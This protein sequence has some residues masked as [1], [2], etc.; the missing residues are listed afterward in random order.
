M[1]INGGLGL[2][3]PILWLKLEDY[4]RQ[5]ILSF[6]GLISDPHGNGYQIIQ[7]KVAI[8]SGGFWGKGFIQGSQTQLR[9]LPEQHTDFIF[10]VLG[11]E[12]GFI[13][14]FFV[15]ALL[16]WIIRQ[17]LITAEKARTRFESSVAI[18]C[19]TVIAYQCIVNIG[20]T[21]GFFPITGLPLP[22]LSYGGTSLWMVLVLI[23]LLSNISARRYDY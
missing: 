6:L 14:C 15:L 21:L 20:M 13:G 4:Q 17:G 19:V 9:F 10:S 16:F 22:F 11:E 1:L 5:R 12:F 2:F 8:G 23:G 7:S 18:G 3:A